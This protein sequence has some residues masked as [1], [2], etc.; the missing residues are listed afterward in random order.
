MIPSSWQSENLDFSL[1][2]D[3]DVQEVQ[4]IFE[5]N[6]ALGDSDPT[7]R[8]YPLKE[9]QALIDRDVTN[10]ENLDKPSFYLRKISKQGVSVGYVQIELDTP[11]QGKCW[12]PML[13]LIPTE[14]S[15]GLGREIVSSVLWQIEANEKY[16]SIGL[17]VYAE[18]PKALMFW[19]KNGFTKISGVDHEVTNYK[20][21]TCITL[22]REFHT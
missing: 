16:T 12:L 8:S 17:N 10:S 3:K 20:S 14:Q 21:Y 13:V 18:N 1:F 2:E 22:W 11:E 7:F 19:F 4:R 15:G 9:Y 6:N 5:A